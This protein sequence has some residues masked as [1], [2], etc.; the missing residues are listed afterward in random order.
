MDDKFIGMVCRIQSYNSNNIN[1]CALCNHVG[2]R[3]EVAFVS[4]L[5]KI[6]NSK[7]EA[8]KSIAFNVCLDSKQCNERLTSIKK[9]EEILKCVNNI[10]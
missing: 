1:I 9:L 4:S 8:Y 6:H 10:K 3:D 5:C 7:E 2:I